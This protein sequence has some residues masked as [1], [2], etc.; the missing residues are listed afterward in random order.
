L[1]SGLLEVKKSANPF[2]QTSNGEYGGN[3]KELAAS[4]SKFNLIPGDRG[5]LEE[6]KSYKEEDEDFSFLYGRTSDKYGST[7][8]KPERVREYTISKA[9]LAKRRRETIRLLDTLIPD[10]K[11]SDGFQAMTQ[12]EVG[13]LLKSWKQGT[14]SEDPRYTTANNQIGFKPPTVATFVSE[15]FGVGQ[16]FTRSFNNVKPSNSGMNTGLT[17]SSVHP[18]LDPQFA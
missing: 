4:T 10:N 14:K 18:I 12:D 13:R 3:I 2:F 8:P 16:D 11:K 15:R 7:V 1:K 17:R 9:E 5:M 6:E